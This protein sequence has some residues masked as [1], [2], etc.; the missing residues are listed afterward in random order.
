MGLGVGSISILVSM[1][2]ILRVGVGVGGGERVYG[3]VMM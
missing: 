2:G 1:S 3:E